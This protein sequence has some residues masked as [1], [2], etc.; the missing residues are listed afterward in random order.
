[1]AKCFILQLSSHD[2]LYIIDLSVTRYMQADDHYT[3]IYYS[4][5]THFMV[6]FGLGVI[7][8]KLQQMPEISEQF[9]RL[10][11]SCIVNTHHIF[12]INT[13]KESISLVDFPN[14]VIELHISKPV[15]RNLKSKM[16]DVHL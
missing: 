8:E 6:P 11:R 3:H 5:T 1:M 7:E 15:L 2:E 12:R 9:S 14:G 16:S 4:S 13:I 10:G